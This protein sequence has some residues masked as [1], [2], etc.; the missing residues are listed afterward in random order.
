[1]HFDESSEM[2]RLGETR[3][4]SEDIFDGVILHVKRDMVSLSKGAPLSAK[5]SA[6]SARSA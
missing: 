6:I 3:T 1:M 4:S 2:K 5:S